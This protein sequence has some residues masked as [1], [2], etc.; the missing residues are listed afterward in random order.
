MVND[1]HNL[2]KIPYGSAWRSAVSVDE[3]I[4]VVS[5]MSLSQLDIALSDPATQPS[6][7]KRIEARIRALRKKG[8]SND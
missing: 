1:T 5:S 7:R 2:D 6:V 3:R 8:D 4:R